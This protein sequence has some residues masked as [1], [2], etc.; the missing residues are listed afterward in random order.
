MMRL[1]PSGYIFKSESYDSMDEESSLQYKNTA[2]AIKAAYP[3]LDGWPN[4]A[5]A[6]SFMSYG[7]ALHYCGN[8]YDGQERNIEFIAYLYAQQELGRSSHDHYD[9]DGLD[10]LDQ[11]WSI[12]DKR[13]NKA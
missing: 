4:W 13:N 11:E 7:E 1:P 3:E 9:V 10:G 5:C 2:D 8:P 6:E 12:Y